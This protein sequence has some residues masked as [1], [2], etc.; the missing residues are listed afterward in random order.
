MLISVHILCKCF[1]KSTFFVNV[2]D[3]CVLPKERGH[4]IKINLADSVLLKMAE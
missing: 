1:Q 4:E 2:I 3:L